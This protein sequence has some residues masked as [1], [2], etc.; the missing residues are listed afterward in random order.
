V[1]VVLEGPITLL[2]GGAAA[3]GGLL[4][5]LPVLLSAVLGNLAADMGWYSL[6]RF[7]K[8]DWLTKF[9]LKIRVD[10]SRMHQ[11]LQGI[12][13]H[14]PRLL[15][16]SK[17]T[18]GFPNPTLIATGLGRVP[19]RRWV[20][21]LILGEVIKSA[22][23]VSIVYL[24]ARVIIQ[25][26]ESIQLILLGVTAVVILVGVSLYLLKKKKKLNSTAGSH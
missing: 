8:L 18:V 19:V 22:A 21:W 14:A 25:A 9:G 2:L 24:Y 17:F 7:S 3:S 23:L 5:P 1:S 20:V 26:S 16:L 11:L 6:G 12:Q 13:S 4:L 10:R 15:F